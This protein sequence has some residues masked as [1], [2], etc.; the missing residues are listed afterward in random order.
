MATYYDTSFLLAGLLPAPDA[1]RL[2]PWWTEETVRLG[3][4]LL[5]AECVTVIRRTA[6]AQQPADSASFLSSRMD[7]LNQQMALLSCN[8]VNN[9]VL[10]RLRS[11]PRLSNCR[12][13]DAL[14][15]ATA[16]LFQDQ[17]DEPLTICT[18]DNRMRTTAQSLGFTVAP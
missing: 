17:V 11:E 3:S 4:V 18:L 10:Q 2:V 6:T 13:L 8:D 5:E 12:T 14:H 7:W 15:L 1:S 16:L 9:E